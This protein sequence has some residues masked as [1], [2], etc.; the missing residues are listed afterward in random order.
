MTDDPTTSNLFDNMFQAVAY[1]GTPGY[2]Y[3]CLV[4]VQLAK[5]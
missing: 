3:R 5:K 1:P 2:D 4:S